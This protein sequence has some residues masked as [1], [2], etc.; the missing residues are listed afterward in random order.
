MPPRKHV[1]GGQVFICDLG[2]TEGETPL[3]TPPA[4]SPDCEPHTPHPSGYIAHSDWAG[5]MMKT[6]R[7]RKCKGC[8][9]YQIWVPKVNRSAPAGAVQEDGGS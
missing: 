8:G 9:K 3:V 1:V 6:H 7:Q 2:Y 4:E 5:Q